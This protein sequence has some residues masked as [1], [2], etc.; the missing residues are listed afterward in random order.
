MYHA[1]LQN[2]D[3]VKTNLIMREDKK[4]RMEGYHQIVNGKNMAYQVAQMFYLNDGAELRTYPISEKMIQKLQMEPEELK[5]LAIGN[6][7]RFSMLHKDKL[8]EELRK[9]RKVYGRTK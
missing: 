9:G 7:K 4:G 2:S 8:Q 6:M 1:Y 5:E 3:F